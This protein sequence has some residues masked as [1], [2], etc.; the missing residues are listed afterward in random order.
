MIRYEITDDTLFI[1]QDGECVLLAKETHELVGIAKEAL[2][3]GLTIPAHPHPIKITDH[4][5]LLRLAGDVSHQA[6]LSLGG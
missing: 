4:Q 6:A 3:G 1:L 2:N 5:W